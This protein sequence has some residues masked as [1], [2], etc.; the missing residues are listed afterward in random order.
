MTSTITDPLFLCLFARFFVCFC[1][2][3][4]L[5]CVGFDSKIPSLILDSS[6]KKVGFE[7]EIFFSTHRKSGHKARNCILLMIKISLQSL[8]APKTIQ[9]S[10]SKQQHVELTNGESYNSQIEE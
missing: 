3:N 9:A 4:L 5:V 7:F 6:I 1:T 10:N 8:I 2:I